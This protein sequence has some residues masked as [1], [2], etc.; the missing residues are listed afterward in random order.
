MRRA[1]AE[2]ANH[3]EVQCTVAGDVMQQGTDYHLEQHWKL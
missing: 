2:R 1:D 3:P